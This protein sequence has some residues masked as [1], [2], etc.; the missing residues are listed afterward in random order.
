MSR[1]G[2]LAIIL[3]AATMLSAVGLVSTGAWLI[4]AAALMPPLLTLQVAIVSVRAFGISRGVFR[5]SER[6]MSH[7]VALTG[8]TLQRVKLW[9]AAATLGPRGIWR[10]RGSDALDRLTSDTD[11]LQD[12][13][14]RVKTPFIAA[15]ISAGIL[16][17]IQISLLP[18]AGVALFVAFLVS[19]VIVPLVS[20]RIETSIAQE[21][22]EIRN[23]ISAITS[24]II[25][26]GDEIRALGLES[27]VQQQLSNADQARVRIESRASRW[28]GFASALNGLS[29]GAAVFIGIVG[30]IA[31]HVDGSINGTTIAVIALLPWATSEIIA[32]FS[33]ATTAHTRATAARQRVDG[34]LHAAQK[35]EENNNAVPTSFLASPSTLEVENLGVVWTIHPAVMNVTFSLKRGA[36]LAI[37][38][39]SGSGKS[40]LASAILRLVEHS[41]TVSLD[42]IPVENLSDFRQHV[43]ALLQTTHIFHTTV[44][45]NLRIASSA[46]D[47][48]TLIATLRKSGLESWFATLP[49]GLDTMIGDGGR[50]MSGG[51]IQRIGIARALLSDASFVVLDEPTEHLDDQTAA[52]IWLTINENFKDRGLIIITHNRDVAAAADE[53]LVLNQGRIVEHSTRSETQE[54]GW[55]RTWLTQ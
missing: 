50:G 30:A 28:A 29:A 7:E 25:T 4:S 2:I 42:N 3:A 35:I 20:F 48:K 39:A 45:E 49:Q 16:I 19:G 32:T 40:S 1:N 12:E 9:E 26:H 23:Q 43:T 5:Y 14:T 21:A 27:D 11:I 10:L 52:Q 33:I 6:V 24:D 46:A 54:H 8:T 53:V 37:V 31:A 38:G 36:R 17:L 15:I 44:A 41:G 34:L 22:I 55:L 13:V 51:E 47:D 18:I